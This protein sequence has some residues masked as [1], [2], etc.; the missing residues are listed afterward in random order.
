MFLG[1][2]GFCLSFY[3]FNE[4]YNSSALQVEENLGFEDYVPINLKPGDYALLNTSIYK[5][6]DILNKT[7]KTRVSMD[8]RLIPERL[9][10]NK[11]A[12]LSKGMKFNT[13]CYFIKEKEMKDL[14]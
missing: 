1:I 9:L 6:G 10:D 5:H 12:S 8:F 2:L 14:K 11:K 3:S 7:S 13:D 4:C